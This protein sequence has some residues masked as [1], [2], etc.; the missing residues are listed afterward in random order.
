VNSLTTL[1]KK[2][3]WHQILTTFVIGLLLVVSTACGSPYSQVAN[4]D[5][6]AVQA[7]GQNNPYKNGGDKY[8]NLKM[9]Q[10]G[11]KQASVPL[12]LQ[13][14]VASGFN[15]EELLYP[16]AES[17]EGRVYKEGEFPLKTEK[18]FQRN[19]RVDKFSTNPMLGKESKQDSRLLKKQ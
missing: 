2:W 19:N 10:S 5:N 14:L 12:N 7:G 4:L 8:T 16:G 18:D 3:Q 1:L 6:P 17:P 15:S 13:G 11:Q 9:S